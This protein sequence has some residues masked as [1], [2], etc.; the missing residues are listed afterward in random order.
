MQSKAEKRKNALTTSPIKRQENKPAIEPDNVFLPN[1][2]YGNLVPIIAANV[3]PIDKKSNDSTLY[4]SG[5][6]NIVNKA[7]TNTHVAPV[8][9][10]LFSL[11]LII[12]SIQFEK[13]LE[14]I[15]LFFL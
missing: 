2:M 1:F 8:N 7:P 10:P 15:R 9:S 12:K 11:S 14:R 6:N 13:I 3:S 5:T 4:G